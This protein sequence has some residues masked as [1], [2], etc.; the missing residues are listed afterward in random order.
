MAEITQPP[1]VK[2][3]I[4][5]H[6]KKEERDWSW[7]SRK[8][9]IPYSTIYSIFVKDDFKLN[10]ERLNLINHALNTNFELDEVPAEKI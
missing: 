5:Q 9:D 8:T 2:Q 7:L 1:T 3:K 4:A 6:L 10:Q